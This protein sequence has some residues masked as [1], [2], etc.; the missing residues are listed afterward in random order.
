MKPVKR[1]MLLPL[2]GILTLSVSACGQQE[3]LRTV[4]DFCLVAKRLTVEPDGAKPTEQS[5]E[6]K[7]HPNFGSPGNQFDTDITVQGV[8]EHNNKYDELCDNE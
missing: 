3:P 4:S 8:L 1:L 2:M 5:W 7:D 6:D